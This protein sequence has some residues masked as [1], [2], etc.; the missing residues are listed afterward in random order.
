[1]TPVA[2]SAMRTA[3]SAAPR[4][5]CAGKDQSPVKAWRR[6][7]HGESVPRPPKKKL[8]LLRYLVAADEEVEAVVEDEGLADAAH[9]HVVL[10]RG[11]DGHGVHLLSRHVL[12]RDALEETSRSSVRE[13][14]SEATA[15][16]FPF[17]ISGR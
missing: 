8:S 13:R 2:T 5:S 16:T 6:A 9:F 1:V 17:Q 15:A 14:M 12:Y 10:A 3:L 7:K 11:G 4:R